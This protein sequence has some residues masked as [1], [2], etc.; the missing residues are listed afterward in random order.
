MSQV[1]FTF[2]ALDVSIHDR[3]TFSCGNSTLDTYFRSYATQD[4][5]RMITTCFVATD[6]QGTV[7]GFYTLSSYSFS[8]K[9]L[10]EDTA[11]KLPSYPTVPACLIGRLAVDQAF[12]SQK[13]G[14]AMLADA[15]QRTLDVSNQSIGIHAIVVDAI[16]DSAVS[17]YQ[18]H[19]FLNFTCNPYKLF[20]PLGT[21]RKAAK[22]S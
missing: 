17:F 21:V 9:D 22:N 20:L 16:D 2:S 12:K 3:K 7:A 18:H 14:T 11:R 5:R 13:L 19:G 15:I 6:P 1:I 4:I 10:P 8:I